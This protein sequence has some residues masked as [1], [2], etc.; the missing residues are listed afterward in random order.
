MEKLIINPSEVRGL[1]DIVSPKTA[2]DFDKYNST[3]SESTDTSLG[4][5]FTESYLAGSSLSMSVDSII[6][7]EDSSFTVELTLRNSSEAIISG[8]SVS[9]DV[10]GVST[11]Q[12][13]NASGKASFTVSTDGSSVYQLK[14]VYEGSSIRAGC[15]VKGKVYVVDPTG[16][17]LICD[18]SIMQSDDKLSLLGQLTGTNIDGETVG[19]PYQAVSFYEEW[20]PGLRCSANPSIIQVGDDTVLSAQLI[21]STDGSLV[22]EAGHSVDFIVE[23]DSNGVLYKDSTEYTSVNTLGDNI[24]LLPAEFVD[25]PTQFELSFD[26]KITVGDTATSDCRFFIGEKSK[27]VPTNPQYS[28]FIGKGDSSSTKV[29]YGYRTTSTN[30][31]ESSTVSI[32]G[33][34]QSCK[35]LR[36]EAYFEYY[37]GSSLVGRKSVNWFD[38]YTNY[39]LGLVAWGT[40]TVK[41]KNVKLVIGE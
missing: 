35:I 31:Y 3:L 24:V 37:Q 17:S 5:V 4:K 10:N 25:L 40:A 32:S 14:G 11:S 23:P 36:N 19:V 38:D 28:V 18:K 16:L 6:G 30:L 1:G 41:V 7:T 22:R 33:D 15:F 20:T 39:V 9:L 27:A 13:T 12:T 29:V 34:Y 8:V 26:M 21:D 2:S